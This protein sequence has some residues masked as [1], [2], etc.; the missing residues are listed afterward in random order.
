[1]SK[2][3]NEILTIWVLNMCRYSVLILQMDP[4]VYSER[5]N[6]IHACIDK[7][8]YA[9]WMALTAEIIDYIGAITIVAFTVGDVEEAV[10][11][12]RIMIILMLAFHVVTMNV[13]R[14]QRIKVCLMIE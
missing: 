14:L 5:I 9:R 4:A 12:T 7:Q 6:K 2:C 8:Q 3:F 11:Y 1:M 13:V 10:P